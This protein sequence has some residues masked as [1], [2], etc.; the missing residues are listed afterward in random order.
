MILEF[1]DHD[2]RIPRDRFG[3]YL[4]INHEIMTL[5]SLPFLRLMDPG[6]LR[7]DPRVS[8]PLFSDLLD[9]IDLGLIRKSKNRL[10]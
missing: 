8:G 10:F 1:W 6:A 7:I 9:R 5:K 3:L 4:I 2:F